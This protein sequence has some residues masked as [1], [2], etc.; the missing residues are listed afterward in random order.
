V[1]KIGQAT[2]TQNLRSK[3]FIKKYFK[4]RI[5]DIGGG[6][7]PIAQNIEVFDLKNGDGDAQFILNYREKETYDCVHSSHCLEHMKNVPS[8]LN[9][10]WDLLKPGGYLI[11]IVPH[12]DL[13]EQGIWPSLFNRDHKA[14]FRL[15]KQDSWSP[16]SY[17]IYQL[18]NDLP[19]SKILHAEIHDQNL[20]YKLLGKKLG[21]ISRR[22]H[23]YLKSDNIFMNQLAKFLYKFFWTK[24][25]RSR[26]RPIDQTRGDALAQI[27][28][29]AE[30][31]N[32]DSK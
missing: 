28:I 27:Q 20:D 3:D 2:K 30:K 29:I 31:D 17:D 9:Q 18:I 12:E 25:N 6:G 10:W 19:N 14:T 15:N 5:I 26:G 16:V 23:K 11:I 13:Y 1:T 32:N 22:L 7:D 8:A 4:G 21:S 24:S